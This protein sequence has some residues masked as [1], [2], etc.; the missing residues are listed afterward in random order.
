MATFGISKAVLAKK[1]ARVEVPLRISRSWTTHS[2]PNVFPAVLSAANM[3]PAEIIGD[4][5][6]REHMSVS[7][8]KKNAEM[9]TDTS[10]SLKY[11]WA[12]AERPVS[13]RAHLE[14]RL[15]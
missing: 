8:T 7:I 11:T 5:P 15:G 12:L 1:Y 13:N 2:E 14:V 10:R 6:L 4:T 9:L 3:I